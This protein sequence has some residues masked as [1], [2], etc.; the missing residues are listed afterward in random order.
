MNPRIVVGAAGQIVIQLPPGDP[1]AY[2][3]LLDRIDDA[4]RASEPRVERLVLGDIT[5]DFLTRRVMTAG[6]PVHLTTQ[7]LALL[8]YLAARCNVVV[9]RDE[10]LRDVW[11][12][13]DTPLTRSVDNAIARLRKKIEPCPQNPTFIHTV[14]RDGYCL[15]AGAEA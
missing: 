9:S 13:P 8:K 11:K 6:R 15:V 7:E 14:H 4:I 10:L 12:Y 1:E 2:R 3:A 5:V